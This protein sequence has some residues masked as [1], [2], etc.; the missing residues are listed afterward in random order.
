MSEEHNS[1]Q[2]LTHEYITDM[3]GLAKDQF[4]EQMLNMISD[5]NRKVILSLIPIKDDIILDGTKFFPDARDVAFLYFYSEY[6]RVILKT[7]DESKVT[8]EKYKDAKKLLID[9]IRAQ[10]EESTRSKAVTVSCSSSSTLLASIP[11]ITD[12]NQRLVDS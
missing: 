5:A 6:E 3:T 7:T 4:T 8:F 1:N 12:K 9:A 11:R 2:F 10:P